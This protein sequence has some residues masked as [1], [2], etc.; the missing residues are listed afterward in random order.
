MT[1]EDL[2]QGY[3][4]VL[5]TSTLP[6]GKGWLKL[7]ELR[8]YAVVLVNGKRIGILDRRKAIDSIQVNVEKDNSKLEILVE[9][10]G[11]INFG[12]YLND[13]RKGITKEVTFAGRKVIN[14]SMYG[15][16][17]EK[18]DGLNFKTVKANSVFEAPVMRRGT[19]T[20]TDTGDTYL[21][22]ESWG[23][24]SVW[25]N[26]HH[27]GR[28]WQVGPQQTLYVPSFW[29]KKGK[30]EVLVFEQIKTVQNKLRGLNKPILDDVREELF[31]GPTLGQQPTEE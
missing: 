19:F 4:Y 24:G 23:K 10:M 9:N 13:N 18:I 22:M 17:F 16:S 1:F 21:D 27:V 15:F 31:T 30:N 11:R 25:I 7:K 26:G 28:Y 5:Y 6:K 14:W 3:G 8:D 29:L 2:D 12:K 20:L